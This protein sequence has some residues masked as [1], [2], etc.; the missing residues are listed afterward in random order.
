MVKI[1][2]DSTCDLSPELIEKYNIN[3][4]PLHVL[5][6]DRD[7]KDGV[8]VT[9]DEIYAWADANKATPKTS[10]ASPEECMD[11]L[12][13]LLEDGSEV[14][15]FTISG[16]MS[17][18]LSV[19]QIAAESLDAS[20]R[21]YCIDSQ[22]LS[23]GI[24][25][26]VIE[27]AIM[28][29][30]DKCA[31]EIVAHIEA[32]RPLVRSSFVVD[33]LTYLH[34]GGRCSSVAAMAGSMLKLH[35]RIA[36]ENGTMDAGKKYRGKMSKV[37]QEYVSD[38]EADLLNARPERVFITHSGCEKEVLDA[39]YEYLNQLNVFEEILI[40]RAGSVSSSHCG[41]GTLGVLYIEKA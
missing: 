11:A 8:D 29:R 5:L 17:A 41:P 1:L 22:N 26:M 25:L 16:T 20:D 9:V 34:R 36:V 19:A 14:I 30:E 33:T 7:C 13:T 27:A 12:E 10:A 37:I 21:V 24:G 2:S 15:C 38:M 39:V 35:P 4:F 32:L 18:N 23:T 28:A 6:G 3:I 31:E 40:T